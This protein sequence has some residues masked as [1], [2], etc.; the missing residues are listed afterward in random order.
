MVSLCVTISLDSDEVYKVNDNY[1]VKFDT[2]TRNDNN[3]RRKISNNPELRNTPVLLKKH[4]G[5]IENITLDQATT[6]KQHSDTLFVN[7]KDIAKIWEAYTEAL[8]KLLQTE[9]S[10]QITILTENTNIVQ[11]QHTSTT[12]TTT[13]SIESDIIV[14]EPVEKS[15]ESLRL[16]E[17]N[18]ANANK[19]KFSMFM[20]NILT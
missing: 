18:Y 3:W 4:D 17:E 15:Q 5:I 16:S 8:G 9:R 1:Y 12:A 6:R 10:C 11:V 19:H 7:H 20:T 2:L 13:T 14:I